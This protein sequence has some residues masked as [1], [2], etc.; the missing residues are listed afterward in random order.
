LGR[1]DRFR[2]LRPR[3]I[4]Y[5]HNPQQC[6][7]F[8]HIFGVEPGIGRKYALGHREGA[9][10]LFGEVHIRLFESLFHLFVQRLPVA[11]VEIVCGPL[12]QHLRR[13]FDIG[14]LLPSLFDDDRHPLAF[15]VE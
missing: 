8:F 3:R 11:A 12:K 15:G 4:D 1:F 6:Q 13:P 5:A 10:P 7:I 2:N 9:Q 14:D